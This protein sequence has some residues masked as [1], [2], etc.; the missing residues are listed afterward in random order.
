MLERRPH[1]EDLQR[2]VFGDPLEREAH[3]ARSVERARRSARAK[4]LHAR[5]RAREGRSTRRLHPGRGARAARLLGDASR[6]EAAQQV[7]RDH[8][9]LRRRDA[10]R[11]RG[12]DAVR[13]RLR[14]RD[15]RQPGLRALEGSEVP[16]GD[17]GRVERGAAR[18]LLASHPLA[19]GR[20]ARTGEA[21]QGSRAAAGRRWPGRARRLVSGGGR[22]GHASV[23][24]M[25]T[26]SMPRI[27]SARSSTPRRAW[28]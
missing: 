6:A 28:A 25:P 16:G 20:R 2:P 5:R 9:V 17:A 23:W 27:C 12:Q 26:P 21:A 1:G 8:R 22:R 18:S 11:V 7:G 24:S 4:A 15:Q 19:R 13:A 10:Q 3:L 14:E